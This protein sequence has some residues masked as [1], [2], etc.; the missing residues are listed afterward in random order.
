MHVFYTEWP[1]ETKFNQRNFVER[2]LKMIGNT[3]SKNYFCRNTTFRILS[4]WFEH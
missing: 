1:K 2:A 4:C 3:T